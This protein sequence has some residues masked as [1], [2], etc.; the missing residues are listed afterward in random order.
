MRNAGRIRLGYYPLTVR[1]AHRI[2]RFLHFP[3][4]G[5]YPVVD[6]CAGCGTA[7]L[8]DC[9]PGRSRSEPAGLMSAGCHR[10]FETEGKR[11][12]AIV[13]PPT[14]MIS[15]LRSLR[16][17]V[18]EMCEKSV[19]APFALSGSK[20]PEFIQTTENHRSQWSPWKQTSCLGC[21]RSRVQIPAAR[22]NLSA[23]YSRSPIFRS[24]KGSPQTHS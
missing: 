11:Y 20:C 5:Q 7:L 12:P 4:L 24:Q 2:R 10:P 15:R 6:P 16:A 18:P 14:S 8:G 3:E 17:C 13:D 21:K 9:A 22:P 1:E 23:S 19:S